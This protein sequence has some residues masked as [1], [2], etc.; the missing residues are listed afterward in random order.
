MSIKTTRRKTIPLEAL[1]RRVS[2]LA[3]QMFDKQGDID[4]IWLVENAE[5]EQQTLIVPIVAP[6]P[7]AASKQKDRI[8]IKMR[9]LFAKNG[10]VRYACAVEAWTLK[11][12]EQLTLEQTALQY[13]ALGYTLAN[14]PDRCE[15]VQVD[16][17]DA[18]EVLNGFRDIIRPR[19]G[20]PYL[21][22]LG[23]IERFECAQS[24]WLGLLPNAAHAAALQERPP[25]TAERYIRFS[26]DLPADVGTV[27]ATAVANAPFQVTGRRDPATGELCVGVLVQSP[28]DT[29][30]PPEELPWVELVTGPEASD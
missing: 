2:R 6:T 29:P 1:L 3:E 30:W 25:E 12:P 9:E 11:H 5:G 7:L 28:K 10:V 13:A 18:T 4:P 26:R 23:P 21:A 17:E 15:V 22:R 27:F 14:H 19:H 16:G 24:R 20:K 8:A